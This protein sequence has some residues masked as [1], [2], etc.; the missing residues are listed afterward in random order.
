MMIMI[1]ERIMMTSVIFMMRNIIEA[2]GTQG[3][4]PLPVELLLKNTQAPDKIF[5]CTI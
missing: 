4:I 1:I 2:A 3:R 5:F